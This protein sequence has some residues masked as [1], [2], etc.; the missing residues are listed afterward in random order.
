MYSGVPT[1]RPLD[2]PQ[3]RARHQLGHAEVAQLGLALAGQ[4]DVGRLEVAVNDPLLVGV[5]D[6]PGQELQPGGR[7]PG[8]QRPPCQPVVQAGTVNQLEGEVRASGPRPGVVLAD[9]V[10]LD[11]VGVLQP[12]DGRR[13][14]PE[15]QPLGM[16]GEDPAQQHLEGHPAS[17]SEVAGLVHHPHPAPADLAQDFVVP[18]RGRPRLGPA[19][20]F[21]RRMPHRRDHRVGQAVQCPG[22]RLAARAVLEMFGD[23]VEESLR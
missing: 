1:S 11:D 10:E 5:M 2:S 20:G 15:A 16:V 4:Q 3:V 14:G 18:H 22:E 23:R 6:G 9:L 21:G 8:R 17:Q 12:R 7:L 13:L 19:R